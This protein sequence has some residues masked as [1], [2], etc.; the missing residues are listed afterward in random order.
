M[1]K[2]IILSWKKNHYNNGYGANLVSV[3]Y[4]DDKYTSLFISPV[5]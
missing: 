4:E 5:K 3:L 2:T 1:H